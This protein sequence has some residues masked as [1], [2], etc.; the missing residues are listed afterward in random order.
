MYSYMLEKIK[1]IKDYLFWIGRK[2]SLN[3][4]HDVKFSILKKYHIPKGIWIETGT[5]K[6]DMSRRLS[7]ISPMVYTI[8]PYEKLYLYS[9]KRFK[10]NEKISV[11]NGTSEEELPRILEKISKRPINFWLD[12]HYSGNETYGSDNFCPL[13]TEIKEIISLSQEQC[14]I[15]ID[16]IRLCSDI[17]KKRIEYPTIDDI[18]ELV[19]QRSVGWIIEHD[20]LIIKL[21]PSIF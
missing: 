12:G 17:S 8:E 6:G 7:T 21:K 3:A 10:N 19:K 15:F 1:N 9:T 16:D 2:F 20:I 14:T 18:L 11:I 13:I 5:Y 4:P